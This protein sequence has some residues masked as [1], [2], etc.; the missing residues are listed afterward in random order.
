MAAETQIHIQALHPT[1]LLKLNE[2]LLYQVKGRQ[3]ANY[4]AHQFVH[5]VKMCKQETCW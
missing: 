2:F 4:T 3:A 5:S 1:V